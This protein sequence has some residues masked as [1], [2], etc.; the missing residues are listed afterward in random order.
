[1]ERLTAQQGESFVVNASNSIVRNV[2]G[3]ACNIGERSWQFSPNPTSVVDS[4]NNRNTA[5]NTYNTTAVTTNAAGDPTDTTAS[6]SQ[7]RRTTFAA[8]NRDI[9]AFSKNCGLKKS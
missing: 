5:G 7:V 2:V 9:R 3:V 8:E 6:H 1:M 4:T